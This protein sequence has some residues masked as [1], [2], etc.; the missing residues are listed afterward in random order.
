MTEPSTTVLLTRVEVGQRL[1]KSPAWVDK[2]RN[3]TDPRAFPPPMPGWINMGTDKKPAYRLSEAALA[4]F[5]ESL[6]AA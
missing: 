2:A 6:P 5:I 3:A 4:A 1:K